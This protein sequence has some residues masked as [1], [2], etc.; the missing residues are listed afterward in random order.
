MTYEPKTERVELGNGDFAVF[1]AETRHGTQKAVNALTRPFLHYPE[2][3]G[4]KLVAEKT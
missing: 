3:Q 2:G 4:P 1:Y